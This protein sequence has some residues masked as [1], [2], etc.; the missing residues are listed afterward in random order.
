MKRSGL[1]TLS[2][3]ITS[4]RHF[5]KHVYSK[6]RVSTHA[7]VPFSAVH[8]RSKKKTLKIRYFSHTFFCCMKWDKIEYDTENARVFQFSFVR[9]AVGRF[10]I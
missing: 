5:F 9:A 8:V 6:W 4:V 3:E 1:R 10:A 7:I 2:I